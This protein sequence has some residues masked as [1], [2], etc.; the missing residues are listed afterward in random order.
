MEMVTIDAATLRSG[1]QGKSS[2]LSTLQRGL[3][4][5]R[6]QG[7]AENTTIANGLENALIA[8]EQH[9]EKDVGAAVRDA[10]ESLLEELET[11]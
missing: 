1:Q 9:P 4:K 10:V 7:G 2:S 5:L 11:A 8:G 3:G 6:G